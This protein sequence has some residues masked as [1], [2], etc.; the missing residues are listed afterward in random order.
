MPPDARLGRLQRE[1]RERRR[2]QGARAGWV[3]P[4]PAW[5]GCRW[6]TVVQSS[7]G[8][9]RLSSGTLGPATA[10]LGVHGP[11][12]QTCPQTLHVGVHGSPRVE[13]ANTLQWMRHRKNSKSREVLTRKHAEWDHQTQTALSVTPH[14]CETCTAGR[15]SSFLRGIRAS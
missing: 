2:G 6:C 11:E 8:L 14:M 1:R 9:S 4:G 3:P 7:R 15:A 5:G 13:P 10:L 12:T